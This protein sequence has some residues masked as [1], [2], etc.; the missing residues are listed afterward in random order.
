[1]ATVAQLTS[2][3]KPLGVAVGNAL[4]VI[5]SVDVLRGAGPEDVRELTLSLARTMLELVGDRGEPPP[6]ST[7]ARPTKSTAP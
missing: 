4:E 6:S 1:M 2:M 3:N 5:E 7:T